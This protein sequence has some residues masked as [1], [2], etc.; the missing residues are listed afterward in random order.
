MDE[1]LRRR[2]GKDGRSAAEAREMKQIGKL[3][4]EMINQ[5]THQKVDLLSSAERTIPSYMVGLEH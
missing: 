3:W 4:L 1:E 2:L 5:I